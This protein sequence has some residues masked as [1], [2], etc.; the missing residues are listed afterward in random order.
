[1]VSWVWGLD[2]AILLS[3]KICLPTYFQGP[4]NF[5]PL[6]DALL[7]CPY[8]YPGMTAPP[9]MGLHGSGQSEF[10]AGY[11]PLGCYIYPEP[12]LGPPVHNTFSAM[13]LLY[14]WAIFLWPLPIGGI[15]PSLLLFSGLRWEFLRYPILI[16]GPVSAGLLLLE[17]LMFVPL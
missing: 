12:L 13:D 5:T 17:V 11:V 14:L 1:M 15:C 9:F 10:P 8:H 4:K 2:M 3:H 16:C 7:F 6:I